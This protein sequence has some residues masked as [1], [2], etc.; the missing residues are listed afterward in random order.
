L[1]VYEDGRIVRDFVYIDD[2]VD[3]LFAAI[4]RPAA[5]PRCLDIGSGNPT[6]IHELAR[7]LA[8]ICDAPEPIVVRKFRDGDVRAA[9]CDIEPAT[10]ELRWRPKWTLG[11]GLRDLL[12]WISGQAES[13]S[14]PSDHIEP[15]RLANT[16]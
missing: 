13:P 15:D 8:T 9:R 4:E 14:E 7:K 10:A 5:Q 3:A 12:D 6:T 2:V 16:P 11:A 1:E